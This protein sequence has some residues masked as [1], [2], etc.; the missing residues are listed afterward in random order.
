MR[1]VQEIDVVLEQHPGPTVDLCKEEQ[2]VVA[3]HEAVADVLAMLGGEIHAGVEVQGC[4]RL[5]SI[6]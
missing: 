5:E 4:H 3:V 6:G 2:R 1:S